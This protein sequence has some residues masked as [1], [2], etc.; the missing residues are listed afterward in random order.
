MARF[1]TKK[2]NYFQGLFRLLR[3]TFNS[4]DRFVKG[5]L[6]FSIILVILTPIITSQYLTISQ[7]AAVVYDLKSYYPNTDFFKNYYLE[8]KNYINSQSPTRSVLWFEQQDQ[9]TFKMYNSAPEDV[10]K[11]CHYD[12]LSWWDDGFLRY[13]KT[14]DECPGQIPNEIVYDPPIIFLPRTWDSSTPWSFSGQSNAKYYQNGVVVCEGTNSYKA[15]IIGLEQIAPNEQGIHW[16][17]TQNTSWASGSVPGGCSAGYTTQWQEDYWLTDILPTQNSGAAKA[18]KRSNGGNKGV[19]SDSW[20]I[21]FDSW[22]LL[23]WAPTPV[24]TVAPTPTPAPTSTPPPID[25]TPPM[26]S[27]TSPLNG[28]IV[29]KSTA[30]TLKA[31]A[32]DNVAVSRA[33]FYYKGGSITRDTL[34]CSVISAPYACNWTTPNPR[35]KVYTITA[36]AYDTSNNTSSAAVTLNVR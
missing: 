28:T 30:I 35:N 17:T 24:P 1:V 16:K 5:F 32:S 22:K 2:D 34:I 7:H 27:I 9:W 18:L 13:V 10:N 26:V 20:D 3:D 12:Q 29:P 6:V 19:A 11:K 21:W 23:P 15:E 14:H 33:E 4:L 36:K 25:K 8:G 31:T